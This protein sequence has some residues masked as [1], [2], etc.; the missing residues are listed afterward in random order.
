MRRAGGLAAL[1]AMAILVMAT[2]AAD[3]SKQSCV[4]AA[5]TAEHLAKPIVLER[6]GHARQFYVV[7]LNV[8][9]M[10]PNCKS[11][12]RVYRVAVELTYHGRWREQSPGAPVRYTANAGTKSPTG[13]LISVTG[14]KEADGFTGRW[15]KGDKVR[16]VFTNKV[17]NLTTK[18]IVAEKTFYKHVAVNTQP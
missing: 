18:K 7:S 13:A 9:P 2:S 16:A 5:M 8:D 14:H 17:I 4:Q 3:G 6:A 1:L 10:P 12:R 15:K 11:Y